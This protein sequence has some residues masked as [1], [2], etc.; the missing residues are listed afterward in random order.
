MDF[1]AIWVGRELAFWRESTQGN[2]RR[3]KANQFQGVNGLIVSSEKLIT[4]LLFDK[5][6]KQ[7]V[8]EAKKAGRAT[9][10][11]KMVVWH[12]TRKDGT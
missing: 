12:D 10:S 6:S 7:A 2:R 1:A 3:R 11:A 5:K 8:R 4:K 9:G